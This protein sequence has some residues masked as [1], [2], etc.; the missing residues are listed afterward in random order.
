MPYN[1]EEHLSAALQ[2]AVGNRPFTP[3]FDQIE[4]RGRKLR[5]RRLAWRAT[6][7]TSFAAAAI[8]AVA[9]ATSGTGTTAPAQLAAP[10]PSVTSGSTASAGATQEAP[11]V[12]LVG[13]LTTAEQPAGDATLLLR[14]QVYKTGLK[15]DVWDLH[16]DNGDY[17][18]AKT[19]GALPAQVKGKHLQEDEAGRKAVVAAAKYAAKG[20]LNDARK[21]MAFA[22]VPKNPKVKPT[23]E[24]PGV[25]PSLPAASLKKLPKGADPALY[26]VNTT[27]NWVWNNSMDALMV[28]AGSPTVRAGVLRLLN[29]MPEI[30]VAPGT[31]QGQKVLTLTAGQPAIGG[32]DHES[33]VINAESG[34]PI[35]YTND[36]VTVNYTVERVTIADVAKGKF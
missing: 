27:D 8:A 11:L 24:A 25:T 32:N 17:Y 20:D 19:K 3:D 13:Y 1:T 2:D 6:A 9:V 4:A 12:Q 5:N 15:V 14:D 28:G 10:K 23:L 18:F 21:K 16:A 36:F 29:Q 22:Y 33:L 30:K 34:L 7:G 35:K 31:Y 26:A